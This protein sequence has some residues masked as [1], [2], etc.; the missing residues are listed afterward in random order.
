MKIWEF[1]VLGMA[2]VVP[3]HAQE[4]SN[5]VPAEP[6]E[7]AEP[8]YPRAHLQVGRQGW[9][10]ISYSIDASGRPQNISVVD[11]TGHEAFERSAID[12][13][14]IWRFKPAMVDGKPARQSRNQ[15]VITFKISQGNIG[16]NRPF[17]RRY[18]KMGELIAKGRL[19]EA[20]ENFHETLAG[21]ALSLYEISNLWAQRARL[22]LAAGDPRALRT[23]VR[24]ATISD[25]QWIN[26][27]THRELLAL[28]VRAELNLGNWAAALDVFEKLVEIS[29]EAD[30][31][32]VSLRPFIDKL[33]DTID[34][35][36]ALTTPAEIRREEGCISCND[37]A[38]Q[39]LVHRQF[40]L[41]EVA[42]KLDAIEIQCDRR[43]YESEISD[44][45][46]WHIP[47]SWGKCRADVRGAPGTTFNFVQFPAT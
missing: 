21:Y 45:V 38:S 43:R 26:E 41:S 33:V 30:P 15:S 34:S 10:Q 29:G 44:V 37:S 16:A 6:L 31:A 28:R 35:G 13:V 23:A 46:E 4:T 8:S 1:V 47:E 19:D 9:V 20:R 32:V 39:T 14:E 5:A 24:R 40:A 11:S 18:E 7:R 12:A 42:G 3:A 36:I 22:E 2:L 25:G 17:S 27:E